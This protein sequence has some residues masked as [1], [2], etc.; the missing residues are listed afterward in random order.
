MG[1][2]LRW[3]GLLM[4]LAFALAPVIWMGVV[5]FTY[6]NPLDYDNE[7]FAFWSNFVRGWTS[8]DFPRY[9]GHS[10]IISG[11]TV[12]VGLVIAI[13]G[14][15][16]LTYRTGR[17]RANW[18]GALAMTQM[19]PLFLVLL[20]LF[21]LYVWVGQAFNV[22][23]RGTY[24][25]L[26]MAH[27]IYTVPVAAWML[28]SYFETIPRSLY[29]AALLDGCTIT[30]ALRFVILP[31]IRP[32]IAATAVF[33]F[34]LSWNELLLVSVLSNA[35]TEPFSLH[36]LTFLGQQSTDWGQLMAVGLIVSVPLAIV[37]WSVHRWLL[38][39]AR[40]A[41]AEFSD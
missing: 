34:V 37:F 21:M 9:A 22:A 4:L 17:S 29:E 14:A 13:W 36:L 31:L 19:L 33:T 15:L 39:S 26:I 8:F 5:A 35:D 24:P 16:G 1:R 40:D 11:G 41:L 25:G 3:I 2:A 32:G 10:L 12:V 28:R 18:D 27:V 20:P 38:Q 7:K 30:Q 6:A 23:V